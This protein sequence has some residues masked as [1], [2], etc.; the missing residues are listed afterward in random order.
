MDSRIPRTWFL[1][2]GWSSEFIDVRERYRALQESRPQETLTCHINARI[3]LVDAPLTLAHSQL[4][5]KFSEITRPNEPTCF[6]IAAQI[7]RK[8]LFTFNQVLNSNTI[9][10]FRELAKFTCTKENYI[11]TLVL[12]ASAQEDSGDY[13]IHLVPYFESHAKA[14]QKRFI[15]IH[16]DNKTG[17][18]LGWLG[19]RETKVDSWKKRN[20][21]NLNDIVTN[22]WR[23]PE[24][25]E[26]LA[27]AWLS[28]V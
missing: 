3:F 20:K 19:V 28:Q 23:L 13:K 6:Q 12:R 18:L 7:I 16:G 9:D 26:I 8:A 15:D 5:I 17:G 24:L 25:A 21:K 22:V 1:C 4:A 11:K 10:H 2:N 14:C 27:K